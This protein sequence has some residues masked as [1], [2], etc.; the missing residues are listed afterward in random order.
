M[1]LCAQ[2]LLQGK[3]DNEPADSVARFH[4]A[5]GASL[6]RLN[7]MADASPAGL[8]RSFGIMANYLYRPDDLERNH[9]VY[10]REFR[11]IASRPI[12]RLVRMQD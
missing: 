9:E 6:E 11:V 7:W 8:Q 5:N 3:R 4:L 1:A 10:A 12:E 2:Y